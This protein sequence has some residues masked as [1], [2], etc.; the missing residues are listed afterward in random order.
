M[1]VIQRIRQK[2]LRGEFEVS[3]H[4][5]DELLA[6]NFRLADAVKGILN[7]RVIRTFT[8]EYP[9]ARYAIEGKTNDGRLI[10]IICCFLSSGKVRI[11]TVYEVT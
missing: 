6:D 4:T 7:G 9:V 5:F 8:H 1:S 10:E 11:I 3:D 2:V